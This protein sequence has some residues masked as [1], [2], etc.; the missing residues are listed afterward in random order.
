MDGIKDML[1]DKSPIAFSRHPKKLFLARHGQSEFNLSKRITGQLNSPLTQ[2][3]VQQAQILAS[4]LQDEPLSAVYSSPLDRAIDT[5]QPTADL[6]SLPII[7]RDALREIHCGFLQGRFRDGRDAETWQ[8]WQDRIHHGEHHRLAGGESFHELQIRVMKC[9]RQLLDDEQGGTV[10][11]VAHRNPI[12]AIL[13]AI[14]LSPAANW[15]TLPI[16][17]RCLYLI[18]FDP[19]LAVSVIQMGPFRSNLE[20]LSNLMG[21]GENKLIDFG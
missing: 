18:T 19:A 8:L 4:F 11:L 7:I 13:G 15:W 16:R 14:G 10:L 6:H 12:R 20:Q 17:S 21:S 2:E 5:A 3:G 1:Q 9:V